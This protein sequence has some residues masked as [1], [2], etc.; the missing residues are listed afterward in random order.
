MRAYRADFR[1]LLA[2]D[3]VPAV[4]A[5][6]DN[7]VVLG[8]HHFVL[9]IGQQLAV[10]LLVLLLDSAHHFKQCGD[11]SEAFFS[12]FLREGLVHIGPFVV[13]AGCRVLQVFHGG[14][15]FAVVKQLEP[16]FGVLF[17]I[18]SGFRENGG[19]LLKAVFF[20]FGRIIGILVSGLR[21]PGKSGGEIGGGF[22]YLEFYAN[23]LLILLGFCLVDGPVIC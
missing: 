18:F 15:D 2:D 5:L 6:P 9:N 11:F 17:L 22:Y 4:A 3:N 7:V 1:R 12:G 19:D 23:D 13:F 10:T 20:G 8:E 21:F 16:D 14:G